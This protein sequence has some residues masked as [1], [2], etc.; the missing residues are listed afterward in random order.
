[1]LWIGRLHIPKRL[2]RKSQE[3][4]WDV[5]LFCIHVNTT[6]KYKTFCLCV[7]VKISGE[8]ILFHV[9]ALWN[10]FY[11]V[12]AWCC[13]FSYVILL[14]FLLFTVF[15]DCFRTACIFP[16]VSYR[17]VVQRLSGI[18]LTTVIWTCRYRRYPSYKILKTYW[19]SIK[20]VSY[21]INVQT[22]LRQDVVK[23]WYHK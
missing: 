13:Q 22:F 2:S 6:R 16:W 3:T 1:M 17:Q 15:E 18:Y 12:D 8:N 5:Y 14:A 10:L 20:N 7:Q 23:V 21:K 19:K 9:K 11:V 4:K